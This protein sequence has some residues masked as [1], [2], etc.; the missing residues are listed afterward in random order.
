MNNFPVLLLAESRGLLKGDTRGE[1]ERAL[2]PVLRSTTL[3][4]GI[5]FDQQH[6]KP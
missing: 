2:G 4:A 3:A 6:T 1:R 5:Q